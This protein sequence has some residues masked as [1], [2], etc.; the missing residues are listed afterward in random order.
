MLANG[1]TMPA[2]FPNGP[3]DAVHSV[4]V[5]KLKDHELYDH[6][7]GAWV[8]ILYRFRAAVDSG[9]SVLALMKI[10][11]PTP[12]PV[13]R[14]LQE[15]AL[16]EFFSCSFSVFEAAI[17]AYYTIGAFLVP[18]AFTLASARDQQRVTP[19]RTKDTFESAFNGDPINA[20]FVE[21]FADSGYQRLREIRN[22][23]T[24]RAAP[25]RRIY[26]SLGEDTLPVE[27][28]I[29][30]VPFDNTIITHGLADLGRL[31][32][33]LLVAAVEFTGRHF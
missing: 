11:G 17:Y 32:Q 13:E 22:I 25:G 18:A 6:F 23:L 29:N 2:D 24:H 15:R 8:A 16:F 27:W 30:N 7:A 9:E 4:I 19:Q 26:I 14:Y 33:L 20:V 10:H 3:Y 12:P 31:S 1:L 5:G 28:K 21:L